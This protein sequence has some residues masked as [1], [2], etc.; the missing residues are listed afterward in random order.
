MQEGGNSF[1]RVEVVTVKQIEGLPQ[2][3]YKV[4]R[5]YTRF[6]ALV[7]SDP[8]FGHLHMIQTMMGTVNDR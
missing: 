8:P 3:A 7:L 4:S 6:A 5:W 2:A 1:D